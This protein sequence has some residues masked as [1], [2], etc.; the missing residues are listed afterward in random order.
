MVIHKLFERIIYQ[1]NK[2]C[3]NLYERYKLPR[4]SQKIKEDGAFLVNRFNADK[5]E[6]ETIK[7]NFPFES[8]RL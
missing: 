7:I 3:T 5:K 4:I 8:M 6:L 2:N 1:N